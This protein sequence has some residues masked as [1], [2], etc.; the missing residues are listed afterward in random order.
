MLYTVMNI[1]PTTREI[2]GVHYS[3]E[4]VTFE[5]SHSIEANCRQYT[6]QMDVMNCLQSNGVTSF[7]NPGV[8]FDPTRNDRMGSQMFLG[9]PPR[10]PG[11]DRS[12]YD[13]M[14]VAVGTILITMV[15]HYAVKQ[16]MKR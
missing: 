13:V 2:N 1:P 11:A 7:L 6:D 16:M 3:L 8:T 12:C 15:A 10:Y 5:D 4:G 9:F 14:G